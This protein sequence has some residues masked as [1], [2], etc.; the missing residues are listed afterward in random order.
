MS[1]IEVWLIGVA[2]AI[3]CFTVSIAV[4]LQAH[5]PRIMRMGL[6][7]LSFGLFQ[8]GMTWLGYQGRSF[9]SDSLEQIDHWVAF[10]LLA[11]TGIRMMREGLHPD[12][13]PRV[14]S[15]ML[16]VRNILTLSVATSIDALAV[17][18]S[19]ACLPT[20]S[21]PSM[22]HTTAVIGFCSTAL[23]ICGL[24]AGII[25]G[26]KIN[27]HAEVIGGIVLILIGIKILIEHLT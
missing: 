24:G 12:D 13:E 2:L 23:S 9:F 5:R 3:D 19:F 1:I 20:A 11:Y 4:G 26:R 22:L 17:G 10:L 8:G 15:R 6:M 18:L 14:G 21:L 27:W 16:N 7:A 25:I